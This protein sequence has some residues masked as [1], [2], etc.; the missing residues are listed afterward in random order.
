MTVTDTLRGTT[1]RR[2]NRSG[3]I[4]AFSFGTRIPDPVVIGD[5]TRA[6]WEAEFQHFDRAERYL[7]PDNLDILSPTPREP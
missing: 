3:V 5:A 6:A 2:L 1:I 4:P 7:A